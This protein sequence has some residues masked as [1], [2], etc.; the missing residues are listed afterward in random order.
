MTMRF[1]PFLSDDALTWRDRKIAL[2][3]RGPRC[4]IRPTITGCLAP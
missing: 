3:P 2:W 1:L 4:R